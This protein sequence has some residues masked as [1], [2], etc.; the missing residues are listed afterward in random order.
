MNTKIATSDKHK[1]IFGELLQ[2]HMASNIIQSYSFIIFAYEAKEK[3]K[4]A[5]DIV[6]YH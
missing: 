3:V 1:V 2:G 4:I 6:L 5:N